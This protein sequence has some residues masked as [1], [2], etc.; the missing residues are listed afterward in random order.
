[1]KIL[2]SSCL[3]GNKVRWN[4]SQ[5]L[6]EDLISWC[7]ENN[8]EIIPICPED[9]LFGTP[10]APINL[11]QIEDKT[12]AVMKSETITSELEE[13]AKE[14]LERNP[15][16]VGFIGMFG[17]PS[18]GISVGVKKAGKF[19]KGVMHKFAEIPTDD[20]RQM[21]NHKRRVIF[22]ERLKKYVQEK[23]EKSTMVFQESRS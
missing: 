22:L 11:V 10:R 1:M 6:N 18:C 23:S 12:E 14:I 13:K 3:L 16:A 7:K 15:D 20:S 4:G 17:S 19:S 2:V 21:K 5:K 8:L 9:E